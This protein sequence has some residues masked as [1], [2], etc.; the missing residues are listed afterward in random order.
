MKAQLLTAICQI[1]IWFQAIKDVSATKSGIMNIPMVLGVVI[2]SLLA[3]ALVTLLGYYTP[4]MLL[5]P[6]FM[7]TGA[8]LLSTMDPE[9]GHPA[10][11]GYQAIYGMGVGLGLQQPV[12][13]IQAVL[14]TSDIPTGTAMVMFAQ[15]FG[16]SIFVSVA[17][18]VFQNK[19]LTNLVARVPQIDARLVVTAGATMLRKAVPSDSVSTVIRLYSDAITEAFYIAVAMGA[20]AMVGALPVQWI[21]VKGRKLEGGVA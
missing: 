12:L 5:S 7:A 14:P 20:L 11:I 18:N 21:S 19:L 16:G 1:P 9:T 13:A 4:F 6:I 15:N 10:W 2:C 8:G 17:Q 3:G